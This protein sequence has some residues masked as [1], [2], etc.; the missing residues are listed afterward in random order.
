VRGRAD[1]YFLKSV[2]FRFGS[3]ELDAGARQLLD[4]GDA[5]ALTPKAF[6]LLA[7]LLRKRPDVVGK[8]EILE[9]IWPEAYVAEANVPNLVAE[10]RTALHDS[11][12]RPTY[13]RT[14]HGAGY[15][16]CGAAFEYRSPSTGRVILPTACTLVGQG[17]LIPLGDGEHVLGR[18]SE[19]E[20]HLAGGA[21]SR[22]HAKI[23]V[24]GASAVIEDLHSSNGTYVR[25][26]RITAPAVL[27]DGDKLRV[28]DVSLRF[29]ILDPRATT[30]RIDTAV[31]PRPDVAFK[32]RRRRK[33][34]GRS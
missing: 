34:L 10:I 9:E 8:D 6:A 1:V 11:A 21:V 33:I 7:L 24:R 18:S 30:S 32:A 26:R 29:H 31:R 4:E 23:R 28:G 19:C 5:V 14:A 16:F 25:G 3:F 27:A 13:I 12:R 22:R 17:R 20:V 2:R 15:A